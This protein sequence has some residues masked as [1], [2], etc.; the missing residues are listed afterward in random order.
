VIKVGPLS[1][2]TKITIAFQRPNR[3]S[4]RT[5]GMVPGID[6]V[7]DGKNLYL[8]MGLFKKHTQTEA[9]RSI[10]GITGDPIVQGALMGLLAG[11][12][13]AADP[14]KKLMTGVQSA[15][16][17]GQETLEGTKVH[18]LKLG[19]DKTDRDL[20]IAADGDPTPRRVVIDLTK[21]IASAPG[22]DQIQKQ[23]KNQKME[24]VHNFKDWRFDPKLDD[25]TFAFKPP[26]GAQE[27]DNLFGGPA[28]T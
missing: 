16:Y 28:G 7:S 24:L 13:C 4:C 23:L 5:E 10:E 14:Y 3:F 2:K 21:L 27:A 15:S 22:G 12:L 25:K 18:H 8:F 9:P 1:V 26:E 6:V 19:D 17:A 11:E 20:W